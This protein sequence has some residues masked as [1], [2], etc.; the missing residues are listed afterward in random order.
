MS[1]PPPTFDFDGQAIPFRPGQS[2]GAA[3][4]AAGI[5]SWR[6][7]RVGGRP[8]GMFCGIGVCFDCLVIVDGQPNQRACLVP[9]RAETDVRRQ[10]GS[11]HGNLS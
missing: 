6:T 11:G 4:L 8:R 9:A 5:R 2:V 7:T 10:E 3:L 1:P